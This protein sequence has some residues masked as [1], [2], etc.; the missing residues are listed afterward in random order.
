MSN[1]KTIFKTA[2]RFTKDNSPL[3]LT[4]LGVT[5]VITTAVLA[6]KASF[7]AAEILR[8]EQDRRVLDQEEFLDH[9]GMLAFTW[10]LY[11]P[12]VG[13]GS[14]TIVA[15][16]MANRIGTRRAAAM[17]AAYSISERAFNEYREKVVEKI[18]ESKERAVRDEVAQDRVTNNPPSSI[19]VTGSGD[20]L[21]MDA[22]SGRYFESSMESLKKAQNDMNYHLLNN[23]Y[24]SLND[25]YDKLGLPRTKHGDEIGWNSD[26]QLELSLSTTMSDD[27]RPCIVVDFS[28]VP[29][30]R[31]DKTH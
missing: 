24:G 18:G 28:V 1:P 16:V 15:I 3:I 13:V 30:R 21:C 6:G 14:A 8:T 9:K 12:A 11:I 31:Y 2:E 19:V 20:V 17:A 26:K 4:A 27:G 7:K 10:Q 29:V 22:H 25:F 5:G 23:F